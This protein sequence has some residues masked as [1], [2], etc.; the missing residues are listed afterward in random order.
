M[1]A[2][3]EPIGPH[4]GMQQGGH[5]DT[6]AAAVPTRYVLLCGLQT[7]NFLQLHS[8]AGSCEVVMLPVLMLP[9]AVYG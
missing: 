6:P 7:D 3:A 5:A 8:A 9:A 4:A 1:V 2:G